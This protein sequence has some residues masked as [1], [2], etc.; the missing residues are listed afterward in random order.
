MLV[1][2]ANLVQDMP[3]GRLREAHL[4][5]VLRPEKSQCLDMDDTVF[6]EVVLSDGAELERERFKSGIL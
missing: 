5:G 1:N 6:L 4:E 2:E 3:V